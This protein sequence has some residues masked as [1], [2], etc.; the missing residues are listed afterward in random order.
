MW[1]EFKEFAMRGNVL[2]L[3]IGVILGG[4]FGKIVSS[5]VAD[6]MMPPIGLLIGRVDFSNLFINLGEGS[7]GSL[8]EA[9]KAGAPTVNYGFFLNQS[10]DFIIVAFAIFL[11]MKG[12]NALKRAE[13]PHQLIT[14]SCPYCFSK[15]AEAATRCAFCTSEL[16][17][18]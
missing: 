8:V 16:K 6:I 3:A 12:I 13:F 14:K 17:L 1:K 11:L 10:I 15:I 2:D 7:F 18:K 9:K 4:A 5:F